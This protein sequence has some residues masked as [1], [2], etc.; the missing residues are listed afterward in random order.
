MSFQSAEPARK[1][2]VL[3]NARLS[4][5]TARIA[6]LTLV[7]A[8]GLATRSLPG[9]AGE[10]PAAVKFMKT[11]ARSLVNAQRIGTRSA[12]RNVIRKYADLPTIAMYS[13]GR[14]RNKLKKSK[15]SKYYQGVNAFMGNYFATESRRNIVVQTQ[16]NTDV[17]TKGNKAIVAS[18][19]KVSS[20]TV[21]NVTWQLV[22]R[23]R[24][25]KIVDVKVLG[26]SLAYLQR[27]LF[28]SFLKKKNGNV[29][30]LIAALARHR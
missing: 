7:L 26:F 30:L 6:I 13:L 18:K 27:G 10:N 24:G 16:V 14:Y 4:T 15:R 23:N 8:L 17:K 11:V 19:V 2:D 3:L 12:F 29:D 28:S 5:K 25:Y 21:Y 1:H 22:K 20:G 9:H